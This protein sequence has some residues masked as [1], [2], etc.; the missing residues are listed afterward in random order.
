MGQEVQI[1]L[2]MKPKTNLSGVVKLPDG[3]P[4]ANVV[5]HVRMLDN[6]GAWSVNPTTDSAGMFS[7]QGVPRG[8]VTVSAFW[9]SEDGTFFAASVSGNT[10]VLD[11]LN[12]ELLLEETEDGGPRDIPGGGEILF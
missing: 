3:S 12:L 9:Q 8:R 10:D 11:E 2:Q 6:P 4:A 5:V 1:N 7:A